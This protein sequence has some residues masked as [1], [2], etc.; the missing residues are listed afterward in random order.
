MLL[1]I[2]PSEPITSITDI[3]LVIEALIFIYLIQ[4]RKNPTESHK[5]H[6]AFWILSYATIATFALLGAISHFMR[7]SELQDIFWPPTMIFGGISFIFVVS[8]LMFEKDEKP[9]AIL[10]MV[11]VIL[12]IGYIII[13]YLFEWKFIIWVGML[14]I[15]SVFIYVLGIILLK[16]GNQIGKYAIIGISIMILAGVFQALGAMLFYT[17]NPD[18]FPLNDPVT[19]VFK[20]HNDGFHF[21]AAIGLFI[22]YLGIKKVHFLST[23]K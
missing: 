17:N 23:D 22:F 2:V 20:P 6:L 19:A 4:K 3:M 21:I 12:V 1:D 8:A 9:N 15:C 14:G 10:L 11:L 13:A 7:D 5:R 16:D 18:G